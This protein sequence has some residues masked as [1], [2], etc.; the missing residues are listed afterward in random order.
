MGGKGRLHT[1]K[2]GRF[3]KREGGQPKRACLGEVGE[4]MN[5]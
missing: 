2:E 3:Q 4:S 5:G 1:M